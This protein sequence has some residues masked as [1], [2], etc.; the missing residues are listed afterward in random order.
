MREIPVEYIEP[1]LESAN[2]RHLWAG[3]EYSAFL[4]SCWSPIII[5]SHGISR[6][7]VA[8]AVVIFSLLCWLFRRMAHHDP[9]MTDIYLDA[10][11]YRKPDGW[12]EYAALTALPRLTL[13]LAS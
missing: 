3:M 7:S 8:L 4:F 13:K 10:F 5:L 12:L 1:F 11:R 2:R 6:Y 9:Y